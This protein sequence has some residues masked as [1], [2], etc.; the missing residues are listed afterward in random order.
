MFQSGLNTND[1]AGLTLDTDGMEDPFLKPEHA[2]LRIL[3]RPGK[4]ARVDIPMVVSGEI[5]GTA[6]IA[7]PSGT[8]DL[9]GL[10]LELLDERGKRVTAVRS[11]FDGFF[12]LL[13][14]PPGHYQLRVLPEEAKRL[15]V[16]LPEPRFLEIKANGSLHE[17]I[18]MKVVSLAPWA[19]AP[20][21]DLAKP[22]PAAPGAQPPVAAPIPAPPAAPALLRSVDPPFAVQAGPAQGGLAA[23]N[24]GLPGVKAHPEPPA[25]GS[26]TTS[27]RKEWT[28]QLGVF[29]DPGNL[30]K[31]Q[32]RDRAW[33]KDLRVQVFQD[34]L[35]G[36]GYRLQMGRYASRGAAIR[37]LRHLPAAILHSGDR[38]FPIVL[39]PEVSVRS[40]P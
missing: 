3:P 39:S 19:P 40:L 15:N 2:G 20:L 12:D 28:L 31:E 16:A 33:A 34:P 29:F 37:A 9:A 27:I 32:Q 36:Q 6:R 13:D 38:P 5:T 22:T 11:S 26:A 24:L 21:G 17:G 25:A 10:G 35:R 1:Y 23:P 7:G 18:V 14:V 8:R 30:A 4:V